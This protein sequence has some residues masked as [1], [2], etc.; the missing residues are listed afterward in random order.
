MQKIIIVCDHDFE[1]KGTSSDVSNA[2]RIVK[3]FT[4]GPELRENVFE[5]KQK[6]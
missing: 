4:L 6:I 2:D 5:L 1:I 3:I